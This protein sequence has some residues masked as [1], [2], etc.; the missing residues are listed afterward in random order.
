RNNQ[1]IALIAIYYLQRIHLSIMIINR[2]AT[3]AVSTAFRQRAA[4]QSTAGFHSTTTADAKVAVLGAAGG[5]GQPLSLL[6]KLSPRSRRI[7][8]LRH[9]RHSRSRGRLIPH[10]H[11]IEHYRIIAQSSV[12]ATQAQWW[13][14]RSTHWCGC[15]GHSSRCAAQTWHDSR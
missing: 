10:P 8:L 13:I 11:Q 1:R 5:I 14:G 9:C 6:C 3:R 15:G 2:L 7:I 12:L 4:V